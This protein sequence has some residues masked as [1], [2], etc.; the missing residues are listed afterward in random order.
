ME[1]KAKNPDPAIRN[2][3]TTFNTGV[4]PTLCTRSNIVT[5]LRKIEACSA[6]GAQIGY[7]FLDVRAGSLD[8]DIGILRFELLNQLFSNVGSLSEGFPLGQPKLRL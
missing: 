1:S 5:G 8:C 3:D 6:G 4:H 7:H 2:Y